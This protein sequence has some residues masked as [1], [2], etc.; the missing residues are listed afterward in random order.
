MRKSV[1]GDGQYERT[2][3]GLSDFGIEVGIGGVLQG[4]ADRLLFFGAQAGLRRRNEG[5]AGPR[6]QIRTAA[7]ADRNSRNGFQ[8]RTAGDVRLDSYCV[9]GDRRHDVG[10]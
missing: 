5:A 10:L 4:Q 7:E 6:F 9:E 1:I 3:C 8:G 2:D